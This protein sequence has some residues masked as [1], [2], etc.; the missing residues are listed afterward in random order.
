MVCFLLVSGF[1]FWVLLLVSGLAIPTGA[2]VTAL[3]RVVLELGSTVFLYSALGVLILRGRC[4]WLIY[5]VWHF[6]V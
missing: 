6:G 1:W 3:G 5:L 4:W 2:V